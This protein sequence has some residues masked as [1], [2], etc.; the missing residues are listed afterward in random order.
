MLSP[1]YS[2]R[3]SSIDCLP[4]L[5]SDEGLW[6]S[7]LPCLPSNM[8]SY[9]IP[10]WSRLATSFWAGLLIRRW[11]GPSQCMRRRPS[12]QSSGKPSFI[13][14]EAGKDWLYFLSYDISCPK[15]KQAIANPIRA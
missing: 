8:D 11:R 14:I 6:S 4:T 15:R 10:L 9:K 3:S 2:H 12:Y 5:T 1:F 13:D 7:H